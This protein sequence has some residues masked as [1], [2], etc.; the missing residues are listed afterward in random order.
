MVV[1][2]TSEP[3]YSLPLLSR[4]GVF[5]SR[6]P[7]IPTKPPAQDDL[8]ELIAD[9]FTGKAVNAVFTGSEDE[10]RAILADIE[11]QLVARAKRK[12]GR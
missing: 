2:G 12:A 5:M 6:V 3:I 10:A 7:P 9:V 1:R 11:A 8:D 4:Y